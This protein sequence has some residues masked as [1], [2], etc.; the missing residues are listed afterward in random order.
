MGPTCHLSLLQFPISPPPLF[1]ATGSR[2]MVGTGR[3]AHPSSPCDATRR[4]V[5]PRAHH[6]CRR[7]AQ[8]VARCPSCTAALSRPPRDA[9]S[10][11]ADVTCRRVLPAPMPHPSLPCPPPL[12]R[13]VRPP[14]CLAR[15][16]TSLADKSR[17]A[18]PPHPLPPCSAHCAMSIL[19]RR[20]AASSHPLCHTRPA[21]TGEL[22]RR[23]SR[24][25]G[26]DRAPAGS[27]VSGGG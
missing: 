16:A 17:R 1:S 20:G 19:H 10:L 26:G 25:G 12:S 9:T 24:F 7:L 23:G 4:R 13:A 2:S 15:H 14:P 21:P 11:A 5:S 22:P 6:T 3:L 8:P 27:S 18:P